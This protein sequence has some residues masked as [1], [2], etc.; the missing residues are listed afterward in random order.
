HILIAPTLHFGASSH[1]STYPGTM[2]LSI[3][4]L[5]SIIEEL[6]VG[7]IHQGFCKLFILNGHGGNLDSL[8]VAS[9]NVADSTGVRIPVS[10]YWLVAQD[11]FHNDSS[12]LDPI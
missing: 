8:K 12:F 1:W 3:N 9:R 10:S 2:S 6:C 5:I 4:T 7:L 11:Y